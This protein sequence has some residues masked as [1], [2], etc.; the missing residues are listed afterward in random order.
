MKNSPNF[1]TSQDVVITIRKLAKKGGKG[2]KPNRS[3]A[4]TPDDENKLWATGEMG[5]H[6]PKPLLRS[7]WFLMTKLMGNYL[8]FFLLSF[9][10]ISRIADSSTIC[11]D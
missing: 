6:S 5:S 2:N 7:L 11:P 8:F 4:L 3:D 9:N 1:K 10:N